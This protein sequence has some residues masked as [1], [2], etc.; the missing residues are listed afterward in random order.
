MSSKSKPEGAPT[1]M[2][3]PANVLFQ[4]IKDKQ[5]VCVWLVHDANIRIEGVML[6]C[7]QFMNIVL[8]D[9]SEVHMIQKETIKIG[10]LLLRSDNVGLIH[11]V[12]I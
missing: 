9:A 11:P 1:S 7:D 6:G 2:I 12:G 10:K 4:F 8:G 3:R 5:R